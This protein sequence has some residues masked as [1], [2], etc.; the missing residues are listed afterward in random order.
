MIPLTGFP[1]VI[2]LEHNIVQAFQRIRSLRNDARPI[3]RL[4]PE[5]LTATFNLLVTPSEDVDSTSAFKD[6]MSLVHVCRFWRAIL[7]GHCGAWSNVHLRGQDPNFLA[8]Q[9]TYSQSA[10]LDITV[11]LYHRIF[12]PG[13]RPLQNFQASMKTVREHRQRVRSL[14]VHLDRYDCFRGFFNFDLP[15]LEEL[16]WE[17]LG[18]GRQAHLFSAPVWNVNRYPKLRRLSV[19]GT[20]DWPM[21]STTGLTRFKLE[22]PMTVTVADISNFLERNSALEYLE[23]VNLHV[24]PGTPGRTK[25]VKLHKLT[26]LSF[27]NVEHGHV[28]SCISLPAL[29]NLHIRPLEQPAWRTPTVWDDL[30]LPSGLTSLDVKYL[31]WEEGFDRVRITGL[32]DT[33]T[34]SLDLTELS[35]GVRFDPMLFALAN[36]P[37]H[38]ITSISFNQ[39]GTTDP[40]YQLFSPSL[41]NMLESLPN[42]RHMDLCWGH[43]THQIVERLQHACPELK[44]LRVKTTRFSCS[45]TFALVLQMAKAR[46]AAGKRLGK[47]ECVVAD[48]GGDAAQTG[49][50]WDDLARDA[51][52]ERY[53]SFGDG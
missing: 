29:E 19:K 24:P 43:L 14:S 6:L 7:L 11:H 18:L 9:I 10:P 47:I 32:D 35:L 22:G 48:D 45:A 34:R 21:G 17:G 3:G 50:L 42:L 13:D 53:L 8:W 39:E 1:Q 28:F 33:R 25:R 40:R 46:A 26:T 51:E 36:T 16:A 5:I 52:L 49:K 41:R 12:S 15:N 30:P 38:S 4:P 31:G 27:R 20:L 23:L 37:L 44:T 2:E